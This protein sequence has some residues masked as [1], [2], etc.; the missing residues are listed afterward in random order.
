MITLVV[1]IQSGAIILVRASDSRRAAA[2]V[3]QRQPGIVR[4]RIQTG[5]RRPSWPTF[6][7]NIMK[8]WKATALFLSGGLLLQLG[9]CATDFMYYLMQALATQLISSLLNAATG[10]ST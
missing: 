4:Q 9:S 1:A 8:A 2:L 6:A 5:E 3:L 10:G 7:E